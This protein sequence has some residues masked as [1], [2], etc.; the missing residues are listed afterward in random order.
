VK[1]L[2]RGGLRV[3]QNGLCQGKIRSLPGSEL[4]GQLAVSGEDANDVFDNRFSA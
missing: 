2:W 3:I 1:E 4:L